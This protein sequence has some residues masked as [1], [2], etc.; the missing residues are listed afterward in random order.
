MDYEVIWL[1]RL[2]GEVSLNERN[3]IWPPDRL[4]LI[5]PPFR[6]ATHTLEDRVVD[7]EQAQVTLVRGDE[8]QVACIRWRWT[9]VDNHDNYDMTL[10][11]SGPVLASAATDV[12]EALVLIRRQ[13][14]P[15]GWFVAVQGSRLDAYP[16]GMG[17]D[18]GRGT[19]IYVMRPGQQA[20]IEDLVDTMAPADLELLATVA[21]QGEY[22]NRWLRHEL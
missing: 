12:F 10:E 6:R 7:E 1:L 18:M 15:L 22:W 19:R 11:W 17:R 16:S 20:R 8:R 21:D 3:D 9:W 13:L 5:T 14:E 4:A 2:H